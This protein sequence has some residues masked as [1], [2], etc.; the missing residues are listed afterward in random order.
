MKRIGNL[1]QKI[2]SVENLREADEKARKGK[3]KTY[4]VK[5]HDK[6]R[7]ANIQSLHEALLTKTFKTSAYDIFTIYEPKER[8]IYRLP[9][10]PDR[11]V[12]H[13]IMNILEPIWVR[14]FTH[15]T[16]SCV[17]GRGIEGCARYVDRIFEKYKGKPMYCLKID[18]KKYY[19]SIDHDVMKRI[20]RRKIK[21]KDLLWLLDEI[22]DS[23]EG[24]PIGNYLSQY[25]ANLYLC[26]FMHRVN[27]NLKLDAAEYADDITFFA[28]TKE[29]LREAFKEIKRMVEEELNLK[30]KGNYQ[31]FPISENRYDKS[32]RAL[33]YVG[34]KFYRKQKLIRKSIK[35]NFCK[36][37]SR[38][39]R[40]QKQLDAKAYKQAVAPWLGWAKHSDSKHLLKSII[41]P[42]YYD[43]IL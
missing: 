14:T 11:I 34:Y 17:K 41:K 3:I 2:I 10:Y 7:E 23:A 24:L 25:L 19:P 28:S 15:N 4:G 39:N 40:R 38:L 1:Y 43:S 6:N 20:V 29:E 18:I 30:I 13:A 42:C 9:Y 8:L 37:V 26:Y 36:T 33:D 22:I 35:K 16:F 5:V 12:H 27:E 32:G 31:I 21:D